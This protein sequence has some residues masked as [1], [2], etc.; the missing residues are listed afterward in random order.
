[1]LAPQ[2]DKGRAEGRIRQTIAC[3]KSTTTPHSFTGHPNY[4]PNTRQ[5]Q[6]KQQYPTDPY[7]NDRP[8]STPRRD[9]NRSQAHK[10]Q[11]WLQSAEMAHKRLQFKHGSSAFLKSISPNHQQLSTYHNT[12]DLVPDFHLYCG[13]NHGNTAP[14][15]LLTAAAREDLEMNRTLAIL[16]E[17]GT[18]YLPTYKTNGYI[19]IMFENWNSLGIFTHSWKIDRINYLIKKHQIDILAGCESQ[20][21][22][23][24]VPRHKKL[25]DIISPGY[26]KRGI[27]AHNTHEK[28]TAVLGVGRICDLISDKG[29]DP[30][31][32]GRWSWIKL[33]TG[34]V[35][36]GLSQHTF[37]KNPT[38]AQKVVQFGN[39]MHGISKRKVTCV[40]HPQSSLMT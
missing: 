7:H 31:G 9:K 24:K 3:N 40:T 39:N 6:P 11:T 14:N 37:L 2:G 35:S 28:G 23:T 19:R 13:S 36:P 27:T 1:M 16:M 32:L 33:G 17:G 5:Y 4:I 30:T 20:C 21:N 18:G 25:T 15:H 34:R 29:S 22:W 12:E 38:N 8:P 26:M 10:H